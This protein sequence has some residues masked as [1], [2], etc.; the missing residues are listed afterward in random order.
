MLHLEKITYCREFEMNLN[1]YPYREYYIWNTY[2][3]STWW[4][5]R[6]EG[7]A[8]QLIFD[9][10]RTAEWFFKCWNGLFWFASWEEVIRI[11]ILIHKMYRRRWGLLKYRSIVNKQTNGLSPLKR[12]RATIYVLIQNRPNPINSP[13]HPFATNKVLK[14]LNYVLI[15]G[16]PIHR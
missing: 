2:L 16:F 1:L 9:L 14:T 13:G 6:N 10:W 4:I 7:A 11:F 12:R 3:T 5:L 15:W 8:I